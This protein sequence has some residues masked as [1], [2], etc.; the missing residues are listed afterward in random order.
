MD[1]KAFLKKIL[2]VFCVFAV[3]IFIIIVFYI[4]LN[5][6]FVFQFLDILK[7]ISSV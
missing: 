1:D 2:I 6:V 3:V 4:I 7:N 5:F